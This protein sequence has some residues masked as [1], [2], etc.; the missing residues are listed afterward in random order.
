MR[1]VLFLALLA[2]LATP[3]PAPAE[4]SLAL[5]AAMLERSAQVYD[6]GGRAV[7]RGSVETRVRPDGRVVLVQR[8]S[9]AGQLRS[10]LKLVASR[11]RS[12]I[13]RAE[14]QSALSLNA[15]GERLAEMHV[16]HGRA[17][18]RCRGARKDWREIAL[19]AHDRVANAALPWLLPRLARDAGGSEQ[20]DFLFCRRRPRLIELRLR[21]PP[22]PGA[23][24]EICGEFELPGS[25]AWVPRGLL[26]RLVYWYGREGADPWLG[27]AVPWAR[28][29]RLLRRDFLERETGLEPA[30]PSLGSSCS[31]N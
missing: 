20:V 8:V 11:D 13:L 12:G 26:P 5:E 16:D 31:A 18:A 17:V 2:C 9:L 27:E 22:K 24:S 19:P 15:E 3:A 7:G 21:R 29:L 30:T 4:S 10:E 14:S 25:L 28:G 23:V 6:G 1:S